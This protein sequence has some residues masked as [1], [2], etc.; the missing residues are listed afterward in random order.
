MIRGRG[1]GGGRGGGRGTDHKSNP[2]AKLAHILP[3]M[4]I[5]EAISPSLDPRMPSTVL[6]NTLLGGLNG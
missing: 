3:T 5:A 2:K 4:C 6:V 1:R